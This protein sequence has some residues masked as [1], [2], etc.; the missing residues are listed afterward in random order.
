MNLILSC[1]T[2][3]FTGTKP[4]G[5]RLLRFA[6]RFPAGLRCFSTPPRPYPLSL[7]YKMGTGGKTAWTWSWLAFLP[8]LMPNLEWIS[9]SLSSDLKCTFMAVCL[10]EEEI[11]YAFYDWNWIIRH[12]SEYYTSV[13]QTD[14]ALWCWKA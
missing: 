5:S 9:E 12:S 14:H 10:G 6:F 11:I 8:P 7:S 4:T 1:W 3:E 13:S 2:I